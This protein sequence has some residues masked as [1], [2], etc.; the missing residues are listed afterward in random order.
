MSY[1]GIKQIVC[2]A[3]TAFSRKS[4]KE[5]GLWGNRRK[6]EVAHS[7]NRRHFVHFQTIRGTKNG[8]VLIY[9]FCFLKRSA[10]PVW[11]WHFQSLKE[12]RDIPGKFPREKKEKNVDIPYLL[13]T[14]ILPS[15]TPKDM[16]TLPQHPEGA[17]RPCP[18]KHLME[19]LIPRQLYEDLCSLL[20]L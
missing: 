14:S 1:P 16:T 9:H 11:W 20:S 12:N 10:T 4:T 18:G 7:L 3:S 2:F 5:Q 8:S 15:P 17:C 6:A 13:I 19:E